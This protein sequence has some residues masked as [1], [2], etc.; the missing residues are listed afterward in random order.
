MDIGA[1]YGLCAKGQQD[2]WMNKMQ[3]ENFDAKLKLLKDVEYQRTYMKLMCRSKI[4]VH[5]DKHVHTFAIHKQCD[6]LHNV[7]MYITVTDAIRD[8][9]IDAILHSIEIW[10]AGQR[11]EKVSQGMIET[12][13][14]TNAAI[15][16]SSRTIDKR[17]DSPYII[18]PLHMAPFHDFNLACPSLEHHNFDI[19]VSSP[20]ELQIDFYAD[21]YYVDH[22]YRRKEVLEL[23]QEFVT[24]QTNTYYDDT[25]I[26][27]KGV[28]RFNL[29]F[30]HPM[31]CMYFWGL[32]KTKVKNIKLCLNDAKDMENKPYFYD[33]GIAPL[34]R[35][36]QS[37]GLGSIDPVLICFSNM[38][39]YDK[40]RSTINFSRLDNPVLIIETDQEE[41]TPFY[42][43]G[44]NVQG[45]KTLKGMM[46]LV[47]SK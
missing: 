34:E 12:V 43:V 15:F 45:C 17:A 2:I 28:N 5:D 30:N 44:L 24:I 19:K 23:M 42:Y 36:K 38:E 39:F 21:C 46:G 16:R 25:Q 40:P 22:C 32:D 37:I 1:L 9:S 29:Y 20:Y 6:L 33:D 14:R 11:I 41:E 35:Y 26:I 13:M 27:K 7:D 4:N 3:P 18:I 10:V 31:H 8:K 47:Y